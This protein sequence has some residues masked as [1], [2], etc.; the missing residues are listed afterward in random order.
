MMLLFQVQN[1]SLMPC[2]CLRTVFLTSSAASFSRPALLLPSF[3]RLH[4]LS[5]PR[6]DNRTCLPELSLFRCEAVFHSL[7][8]HLFI[9]AA[10]VP[11]HNTRPIVRVSLFL[12]YNL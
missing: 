9:P 2:P 4:Q 10:E 1:P 3:H 7:Q 6:Y 11:F 12:I 5:D 8:L